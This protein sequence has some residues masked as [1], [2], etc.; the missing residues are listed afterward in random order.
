M[1]RDRFKNLEWLEEKVTIRSRTD[2]DLKY[3]NAGARIWLHKPVG[4]V[5]DGARF[6]TREYFHEEKN[7]WI[8]D[9]KFRAY[10]AQEVKDLFLKQAPVDPK[11]KNLKKRKA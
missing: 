2:A 8:I 10:S 7:S 5:K 11:K 4:G 6:V 9:S 3:E 1:R